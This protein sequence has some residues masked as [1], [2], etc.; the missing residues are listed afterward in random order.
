[1]V[2]KPAAVP[3]SLEE[4]EEAPVVP[5]TPPVVS[6]VPSPRLV[7]PARPPLVEISVGLELQLSKLIK[8]SAIAITMNVFRS[9]IVC[10]DTIQATKPGLL[11]YWM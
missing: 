8:Q 1:M 6:P 5:I 3:A 7:A 10:N 11:L 9:N 4:L 2:F